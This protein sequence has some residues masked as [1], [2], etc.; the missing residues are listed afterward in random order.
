VP[1]GTPAGTYDLC[2]RHSGG[3]TATGGTTFVV[4]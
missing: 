1:P 3:T 4:S 2:F